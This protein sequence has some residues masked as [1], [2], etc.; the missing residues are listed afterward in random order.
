MLELMAKG[1]MRIGEILNLA[2]SDVGNQKVTIRDPKSGKDHE[3]AFIPRRL[4]EPIHSFIDHTG[5]VPSQRIFPLSYGG[6][7]V[8]V[9]KARDFFRRLAQIEFIAKASAITRHFVHAFTQ[10]ASSVLFARNHYYLM[11]A[12]AKVK[13]SHLVSARQGFSS[14]TF[15]TIVASLA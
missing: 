8:I 2:A 11:Q 9:R 4:A 5:I 1:G 12:A 6:A 10:D 14:S 15:R 3:T 7:R 13:P